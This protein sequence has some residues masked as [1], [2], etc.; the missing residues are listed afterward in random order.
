MVK[1]GTNFARILRVQDNQAPLVATEAFEV[2]RANLL[3][4]N[5][6]PVVIG[7]VMNGTLVMVILWSTSNAA[8]LLMWGALLAVATVARFAFA[9]VHHAG[10]SVEQAR[11]FNNKCVAL[12]T[13]TGVLWGCAIL[14][15]PEGAMPLQHTFIAFVI[16]GMTSAAVSSNGPYFRAAASFI[17]PAIIPLTVYYLTQGSFI[18]V[19]IGFVLVIYMTVMMIV[20]FNVEGAIRTAYGVKLKKD[21][22]YQKLQSRTREAETREQRYRSIVEE[23]SDLTICFDT[24]GTITYAN[25]AAVDLLSIDFNAEPKRQF[26]DLVNIEDRDLIDDSVDHALAEPARAVQVYHL[27][28]VAKHGGD[29]VVSGRIINLRHAP[30]V[31]GLVFQGANVAALRP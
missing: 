9:I 20:A 5:S 21:E 3:A 16:A 18:T 23:T 31:L 28:L 12:A 7:H 17:C 22:L 15:L 29:R 27:R 4:K 26:R 10:M 25:P 1:F 13:T 30:G 2:E 8:H 14:L 19:A 24:A 11:R 6:W